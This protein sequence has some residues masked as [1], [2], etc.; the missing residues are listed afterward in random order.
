LTA[1]SVN[2]WE[3][4][5]R[6]GSRTLE[7]LASSI[8]CQI[9]RALSSG[10]MDLGELG[11]DLGSTIEIPGRDADSMEARIT[12]SGEEMLFVSET[13]EGWLAKAPSGLLPFGGDGATEAIEALADSWSSTMLHSLA[14]GPRSLDELDGASDATGY[15]SPQRCLDAMRFSG[16]VEARRGA[17]ESAAYSVTDWLRLGVA[18]IVAAARMEDRHLV[19]SPDVAPL[20]VE[21]C[22]L[23][24]VPLMRLPVDRSGSCRFALELDNAVSSQ[25]AG[26]MVQ[27]EEG[28]IVAVTPDL[29]GAP[30]AGATGDLSTWFD[31]VIDANPDDM[32]L[33]GDRSLATALVYELHRVLFGGLGRLVP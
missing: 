4:G 31:A 6:P 19:S 3:A 11:D 18:P 5:A 28:R 29:Q 21:A 33:G 16:Q 26:V 12:P 25:P 13:L 10:P 1:S 27:V 7:L 24:S 9:L 30:E 15:P 23:L 17:G 20:D 32:E 8:S 22:F 14:T 2:E